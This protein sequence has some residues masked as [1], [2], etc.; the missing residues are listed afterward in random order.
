MEM[1]NWT[2]KAAQALQSAQSIALE[3]NSPEVTLQ[4]LNLALLEQQDGLIP[5]LIISMGS[6]PK[7]RIK[8]SC[9]GRNDFSVLLDLNTPEAQPVQE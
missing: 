4:H 3:Y 1:N 7:R 6:D 9:F 8:Q 5:Q 2:Q